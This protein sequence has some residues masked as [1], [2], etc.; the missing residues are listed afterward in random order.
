MSVRN[1]RENVWI[2]M[3]NERKNKITEHNALKKLRKKT[4]W[5]I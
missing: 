3:K 2:E 1:D 4:E 5:V